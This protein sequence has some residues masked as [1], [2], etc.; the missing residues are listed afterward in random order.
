MLLSKFDEAGKGGRGCGEPVGDEGD[1][2]RIE[3]FELLVV[4][5]GVL[6]FG[7]QAIFDEGVG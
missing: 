5:F 2:R 7:C 1:G 6:G 4:D 3:R